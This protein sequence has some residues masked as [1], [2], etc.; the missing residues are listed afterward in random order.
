MTTAE[1]IERLETAPRTMADLIPRDVLEARHQLRAQG[2]RDPHARALAM[3]LAASG[4]VP[5]INYFGFTLDPRKQ[6]RPHNHMPFYLFPR[7]VEYVEW[8]ETLLREGRDGLVPKSRD[9][10]VSWATLAWALW[11][12]LFDDGFS[13]LIGSLTGAKLDDLVSVDSMF[14]RLDYMLKALPEWM[15]PEGF[16]WD[17]C[18]KEYK[19][20]NPANGNTLSGEP[21]TP[22]FGRSGR[23]SVIIPDEFCF[24]EFA[25][26]VETATADTSPTRI[27]ISTADEFGILEGYVKSDAYDTFWFRWPD[28]PLKTM[29]WYKREAERRK[30]DPVG[31]AREVDINFMANPEG[32]VYP[33]ILNVPISDEYRYNGY[34]PLSCAWD[35]GT[36]DDTA[37]IWFANRPGTDK[38]RMVDCYARRGQ[39]INFF[40]PI[41][42]GELWTPRGAVYG[43]KELALIQ[44]HEEWPGAFHCGDPAGRNRNQ[45]TNTSVIMALADHG[46]HVVT[47]GKENSIEQRLTLT[48]DFILR[49]EGI[50]PEAQD[51]WDKISKARWPNPRATAQNVT[52]VRR[53]VHDRTSHYRTALEFMAV[54]DSKRMTKRRQRQ[55]GEGRPATYHVK[56]D[57]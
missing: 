42:T 39:Q 15:L 8:L 13:A 53:P 27:F 48:R 20:T 55:A 44:R 51:A 50:A 30:N 45:V 35:F 33:S 26:R 57:Y 5:F 46:I 16:R 38:Y 14:G 2:D 10:G 19:L 1:A 18:R 24:W 6:A 47:N 54:N 41:V 21:P 23:Y 7:Q 52:P 36:D 56:P 3:S 40:V 43:A 31:L 17:R 4:P 25:D 11:H 34:W 22:N 9:M 28:H 29:D 49:L 32:L 12:W 37:L